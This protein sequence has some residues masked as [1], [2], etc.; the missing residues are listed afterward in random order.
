MA[1]QCWQMRRLCSCLTG[2]GKM[3]AV[4]II[5]T[6]HV[7]V[8]N[9]VHY[10]SISVHSHYYIS[11]NVSP[12]ILM[13]VVNQTWIPV[14]NQLWQHALTFTDHSLV[15]VTRGSKVTGECAMVSGPLASP[16]SRVGFTYCERFCSVLKK[17]HSLF[18]C[19]Q[20]VFSRQV[21]AFCNH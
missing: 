4:F 14:I 15:I 16:I 10:L 20:C 12:Q 2:S 13:S 19:L 9:V 1:W 7:M 8:I 6:I 17:V 3:R 11:L 5:I 21:A 18:S